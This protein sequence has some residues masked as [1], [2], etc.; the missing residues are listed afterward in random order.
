MW[1][2][3]PYVGPPALEDVRDVAINQSTYALYS[4][5]MPSNHVCSFALA[6]VLLSARSSSQLV[7]AWC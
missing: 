7:K 1:N 4:L 3:G 2:V 6:I 5:V